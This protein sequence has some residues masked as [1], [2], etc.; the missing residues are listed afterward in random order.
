MLQINMGFKEYKYTYVLHVIKIP[1]RPNATTGFDLGV[2]HAWFA[3]GIQHTSTIV[4]FTLKPTILSLQPKYSE[5]VTTKISSTFEVFAV[6]VDCRYS[7]RFLEVLL[8]ISRRIMI[9][10]FISTFLHSNPYL[11]TTYKTI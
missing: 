8:I 10:S 9:Y 2:V 4:F 5:Q 1:Y 11:L 3:G 7:Y 6:I